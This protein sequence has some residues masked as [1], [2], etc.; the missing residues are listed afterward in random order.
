MSD[1]PSIDIANKSFSSSLVKPEKSNPS[2]PLVRFKA[3]IFAVPAKSERVIVAAT[4]GT[5]SANLSKEYFLYRVPCVIK[6]L[7]LSL[8]V[9]WSS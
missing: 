4:E 1:E 3:S 2:L 8:L 9:R 6:Y 5:G 7:S